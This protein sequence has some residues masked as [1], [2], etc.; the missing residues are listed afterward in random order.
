[1]R[2]SRLWINMLT[3]E[4]GGER[5]R[6]RRGILAYVGLCDSEQ[7]AEFGK[8]NWVGEAARVQLESGA[9]DITGATMGH[10]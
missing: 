8:C 10:C 4:S 5:G 6:R 7:S 9:V 1:M 2:V 3:K